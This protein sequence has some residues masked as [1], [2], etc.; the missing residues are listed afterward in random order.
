MSN[1]ERKVLTWAVEYG[2][3]IFEYISRGFKGL[4]GMAIWKKI[5][6]FHD[7]ACLCF[8]CIIFELFSDL[9]ISFHNSF[10][11]LFCC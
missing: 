6:R 11:V 3:L 2:L 7:L 9:Q 4:G 8:F 1:G 10:C 5:R